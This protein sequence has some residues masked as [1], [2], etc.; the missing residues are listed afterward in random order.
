[1][2]RGDLV[3]YVGPGKEQ[4]RPG[5]ILQ[6]RELHLRILYGTSR[7]LT[8]E[9]VECVT[10]HARSRFAPRYGITQDTFFARRNIHVVLRSAVVRKQG[11]AMLPDL[12]VAMCALLGE[13]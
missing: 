4:P 2:N 1:M 3:W 13:P 5:V 6:V 9:G 11:G 12:F 7:D 8:R 10:I